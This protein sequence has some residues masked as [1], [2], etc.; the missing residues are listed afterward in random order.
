M[1]SRRRQSRRPAVRLRL[2]AAGWA[3]LIV[4]LVVA[5]ATLK[6]QSAMLFVIV[7][8]MIGARRPRPSWPGGCSGPWSSS[9]TCRSRAGSAR[10][11]TWVTTFATRDGGPAWRWRWRNCRPVTSRRPRASVPTCRPRGRSAPGRDSWLCVG[12]GWPWRAS[13]SSAGS[14]SGSWPLDGLSRTRRR[15]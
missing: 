10:R 13:S 5:A 9:A 7:G 8:A 1:G 4:T 6:S 2:T 12:G 11:F 14:P 3:F 15:W